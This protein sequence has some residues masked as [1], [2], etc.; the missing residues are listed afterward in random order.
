MPTWDSYWIDLRNISQEPWFVPSKAFKFP[1]Q[2]RTTRLAT[3]GGDSTSADSSLHLCREFPNH[4]YPWL[5][6]ILLG[7]LLMNFFLQHSIDWD[8]HMKR[9]WRKKKG[10]DVSWLNVPPGGSGR[11][12]TDFIAWPGKLRWSKDQNL[13]FW[14]GMKHFSVRTHNSHKSTT[15]QSV[16][17]ANS[18]ESCTSPS[19]LGQWLW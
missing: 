4:G 3:Q 19:G 18:S 1:I 16:S 6:P 7:E 10:L 13:W 5:Y 2:W 8:C 17:I 9:Y 12:T 14:L 11:T 15:Q